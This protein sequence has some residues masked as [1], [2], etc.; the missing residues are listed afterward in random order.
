M[1]QSF[2]R[3]LLLL[4]ALPLVTLF[5]ACD[6]HPH[7]PEDHAAPVGAELVNRATGARLAWTHGTG[8][9]MHWDGALPHIHTGDELAVNVR[10]LRADGTAITL[11]GEYTVR[12][13]LAEQQRDGRVGAPGIVRLENHGDHVDITGLTNGET[14]IVFDLWH[15]SHAD[16]YTPPIEVE[17]DD[18]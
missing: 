1:T 3:R 5:A 13:R 2:A 12:A 10:F 18:H 11:G 14:Y 6:R 4:A 17:V 15:G 7:G 8:A 9:G 16:W